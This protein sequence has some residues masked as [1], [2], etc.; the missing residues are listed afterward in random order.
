MFFVFLTLIKQTMTM[1]V[2]HIEHNQNM[3]QEDPEKEYFVV[4][5]EVL[6][7]IIQTLIYKIEAMSYGGKKG[8]AFMINKYYRLETE[9]FS[10]LVDYYKAKN[11]NSSYEKIRIE[12]LH[13]LRDSVIEKYQE[14]ESAYWKAYKHCSV[15]VIRYIAV[16]QETINRYNEKVKQILTKKDKKDSLAQNPLVYSST[17]LVSMRMR[18]ILSLISTTFDYSLRHRSEVC[19]KYGIRQEDLTIQNSKVMDLIFDSI[20]IIDRTESILK[21]ALEVRN[22]V[23]ARF[24]KDTSAQFVPVLAVLVVLYYI[25]VHPFYCLII[26]LRRLIGST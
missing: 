14:C 6:G 21:L 24:A 26:A 13:N 2:A 18:V 1:D 7:I 20:N 19:I 11:D 3:I 10:L 15:G 17:G 5:E 9:L 16:G 12:R 25:F 4:T 8:N 23:D 22:E